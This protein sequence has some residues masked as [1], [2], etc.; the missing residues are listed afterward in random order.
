MTAHIFSWVVRNGPLQAD[1]PIDHFEPGVAPSEGWS[2]VV[3]CRFRENSGDPWGAPTT[4]VKTPPDL[5]ASY[6]PPAAGWVQATIY[7]IQNGR[8]SRA[9]IREFFSVGGVIY[10]PGTRITD[11]GDRRIT[12]AGDVRV[13]E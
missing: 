12:D 11:A 10:T 8:V 7:S 1:I 4:F 3:E 13:T 6:T 2:V 9:A 5:S